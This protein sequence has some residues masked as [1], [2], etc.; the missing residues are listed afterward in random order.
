M[1]CAYH[2][3]NV[4]VVNCNGCGRPLCPAC[5]HRVKGFPFC[6]DCIVLGVDFLRQHNQASHVPLARKKTSPVIAVLLSLLCPGLGAAYNGQM[7]KALVFFSVFV[8]LFQMGILI[9]MPLF[10][11]SSLGMWAFAAFDAGRTAQMLRNGITAENAEDILSRRTAG[12]ARVWGVA[13]AVLGGAILTASA[14]DV[15]FLFRGILPIGLI[16]L[17]LYIISKYIFKNRGTDDAWTD[18]SSRTDSPEFVTALAEPRYQRSDYDSHGEF[19][20]RARSGSWRN[21]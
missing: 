5:D 15:G 12:S 3:Q 21:R 19:A 1:N 20:D 9:K 14:L 13:L 7:L 8:G 17:G 18:Y 4:A 16:G 11:L 6:Q 2:N 10:I